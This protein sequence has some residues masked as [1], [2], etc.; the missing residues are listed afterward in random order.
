MQVARNWQE[1]VGIGMQMYDHCLRY[2]VEVNT[3]NSDIYLDINLN[4]YQYY[5]SRYFDNAEL[6]KDQESF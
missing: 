2:L 3:V 5:P 6:A 1:K 4:K